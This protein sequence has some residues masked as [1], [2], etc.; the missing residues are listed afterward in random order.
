MNH[1]DQKLLELE[2]DL[3]TAAPPMA[4]LLRPTRLIGD[5]LV[6]SA[7]TPKRDGKLVYCGRLEDEGDLARGQAATL[8]CVMNVVAHA[9]KALGGDLSRIGAIV[10][11]RGYVNVAPEY[12]LIAEAVNG[13]SQFLLDVFG[14]EVGSHTRTAIGASNMPF[15]VT[16]EVEAEFWL[17]S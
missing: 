8:L 7:Q 11:V 17:K 6:V 4:A 5:R 13:A 1:I 12:S 10:S 15:N 2:I 14:E 3:P 9:K 16:A